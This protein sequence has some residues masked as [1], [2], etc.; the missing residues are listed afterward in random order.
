MWLSKGED[1]HSWPVGPSGPLIRGK[2]ARGG[3]GAVTLDMAETR[4]YR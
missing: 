3:A 1:R 4:S 2:L